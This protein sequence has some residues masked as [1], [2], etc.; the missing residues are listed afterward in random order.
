MDENYKLAKWLNNELEGSEL[1]DLQ[2]QSDYP[3]LERIKQHSARLQ[4]P[5]FDEEALFEKIKTNTQQP[6]IVKRIQ[7]KA[8]V[9]WSV[10]A[11][12]I[13]SL[14]LYVTYQNSFVTIEA[15]NLAQKSVVLPDD[16]EV[17]LQKNATITYHRW[18]LEREV[19]LQC[20]AFFKVAKGKQF[21]VTTA[22]GNVAVLGTQFQVAVRQNQ[23]EVICFEGK[24]RAYNKNHHRIL[25]KGAAALFEQ[26]Q[27]TDF[28]TNLLLPEWILKSKQLVFNNHSF[29][30][31]LSTIETQFKVRVA[32]D[33][34]QTN[35][36]FTGQLPN[37]D[38]KVALKIIAKT[39][40][41]EVIEIDNT[42]FELRAE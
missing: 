14:G 3:L 37:N 38:L 23:F 41:L 31:V 18:F 42:N 10:A 28:K 2:K 11:V 13:L 39:Y 12:L 20:V 15:K 25:R 1:T 4:A 6:K 26:Q 22:L 17:I 32:A 33:R 27:V 40:H 9:R 36:L 5:V 24:V 29:E 34:V 35:Q 7:L 21:E 30:S 16:S 19:D 8:F